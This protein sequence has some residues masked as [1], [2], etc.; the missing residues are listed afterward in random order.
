MKKIAVHVLAGALLAMSFQLNAASVV[1][2]DASAAAGGDGTWGSPYATLADA[3]ANCDDGGELRIKSGLH[4]LRAAEVVV[5]KSIKIIGGWT[6]DGIRTEEP[7][8]T[9][10][11]G[12]INRN[13]VYLDFGGTEI[14]PVVDANG[15]SATVRFT[16]KE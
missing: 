7:S 12:D 4:V 9:I 13:D 15:N 5:S 8:A 14:G 16:A 2:F 3:V 10:V 6:A 11:C 1:Y